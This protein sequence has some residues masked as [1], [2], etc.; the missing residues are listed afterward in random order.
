[1]PL[2]GLIVRNLT[3][4]KFLTGFPM[5]K[6]CH[7]C[8]VRR[9]LNC[10]TPAEIYVSLFFLPPPPPRHQKKNRMTSATGKGKPNLLSLAKVTCLP[11]FRIGIFR[12]RWV[13]LLE[14]DPVLWEHALVSRE[15]GQ[16]VRILLFWVMPFPWAI[17]CC[18]CY[19]KSHFSPAA[20]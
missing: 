17:L 1:M 8:N 4:Q 10:S 2:W 9:S 12:Q 19:K 11:S 7:S 15:C 6:K 16:L 14:Q 3:Y 5:A 18:P 20:I 13:Q